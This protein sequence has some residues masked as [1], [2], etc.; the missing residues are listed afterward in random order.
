MIELFDGRICRIETDP[1]DEGGSIGRWADV[2]PLI[3][4]DDE[5]AG[6]ADYGPS[7]RVSLAGVEVYFRPQKARRADMA[8]S[9]DTEGC[10]SVYRCP[11][12]TS[13]ELFSVMRYDGW[14]A[15]ESNRCPR[16][17]LMSQLPARRETIRAARG[18]FDDD[19]P[20]QDMGDD[21]VMRC[22]HAWVRLAHGEMVERSRHDE[23]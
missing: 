6:S 14:R 5:G 20:I 7:E 16:C 17:E 10:D 23:E 9:C 19:H 1:V 21:D 15:G 22:V 8:V 18:M 12:V 11:Q 4:A 2:R 3:G 13:A